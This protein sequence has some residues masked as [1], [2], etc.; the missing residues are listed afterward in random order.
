MSTAQWRGF[1]G[2]CGH[3]HV[4]NNT[5]GDPSDINIHALLED[6]DMPYT[7]D[8]ISDAVWRT[9][10]IPAPGKP[11]TGNVAWQADSYLRLT[12]EAVQATLA[13]TSAMNAAL[14][15]V[16]TAGTGAIDMAAVQQ[17]AADGALAALRKV[18][19][20]VADGAAS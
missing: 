8:E 9:D 20:D 7:K 19:A 16:L 3:Q 2:W 10:R 13:Q 4:P 11:T 15:A 12:Y 5:H 1:D 17:A 14:Q 6:D 18:A